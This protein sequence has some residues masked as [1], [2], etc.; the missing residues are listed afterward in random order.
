YYTIGQRKGLN[1]SLG[2]PVYVTKIDAENNLIYVDTD[3]GIYSNGFFAE[4]INFMKLCEL[5]APVKANVKIRYKDSGSSAAIEQVPGNK[6]KVIF[7]EPKRS[8]TP[9]QSAVFYDGND[10]IGGGIIREII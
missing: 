4:D 5:T 3:K 1:L 9:G 6:I 2:K 10:V 8:I 7:D